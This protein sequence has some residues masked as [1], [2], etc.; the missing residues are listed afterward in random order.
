MPGTVLI[1]TPS[2]PLTCY[3]WPSSAL[4]R[5]IWPN[6]SI[7]DS[8]TDSLTDEIEIYLLA[9]FNHLLA[10]SLA[11]RATLGC[12]FSDDR[13]PLLCKIMHPDP[14]L[15]YLYSY[16]SYR[17]MIQSTCIMTTPFL[18]NAAANLRFWGLSAPRRFA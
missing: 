2:P 12:T 7:T 11:L 3:L 16:R 6:I 4:I 10:P 13:P 5:P 9:S 18:W 15:S 17:S 14:N 1:S 8:I